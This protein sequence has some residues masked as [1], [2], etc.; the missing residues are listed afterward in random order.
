MEF[1][2]KMIFL[3]RFVSDRSVDV[4]EKLT[5]MN[6]NQHQYSIKKIIFSNLK[7][8]FVNKKDDNNYMIYDSNVDRR[9]YID[10]FVMYILTFIYSISKPFANKNCINN[11]VIGGWINYE[12]NRSEIYGTNRNEDEYADYEPLPRPKITIDKDIWE[13]FKELAKE[14]G[15]PLKLAFKLAVIRFLEVRY[16]ITTELLQN[17]INVK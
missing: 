9:L 11:M 13:K 10:S 1:E 4:I 2:Q 7:Y 5:I 3:D 12:T 17:D 16:E 14:K 15:V 6:E 8:E